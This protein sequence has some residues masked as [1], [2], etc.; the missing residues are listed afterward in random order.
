MRDKNKARNFKVEVNSY[1]EMESDRYGIDTFRYDGLP[2]AIL[3]FQLI[4]ATATKN[5]QKDNISRTVR[6]VANI[7]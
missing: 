3:G 4:V 7:G 2:E 6:L 5:A 1:V